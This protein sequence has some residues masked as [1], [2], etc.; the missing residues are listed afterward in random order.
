MH[1]TANEKAWILVSDSAC[2]LVT[3]AKAWH[4]TACKNKLINQ[5]DYPRLVNRQ[6]ELTWIWLLWLTCRNMEWSKWYGSVEPRHR[7][8]ATSVDIP[9]EIQDRFPAVVLRWP[10]LSLVVKQLLKWGKIFTYVRMLEARLLFNP[11]STLLVES[12]PI[13]IPKL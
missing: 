2:Q 9:V 10:Q 5:G 7:A 13:Q 11:H 3:G 1:A 6:S 12:N 4:A 8:V